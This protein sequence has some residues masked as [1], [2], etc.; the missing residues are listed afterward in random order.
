MNII[1]NDAIKKFAK[2]LDTFKY[3]YVMERI[4][5]EICTKYLI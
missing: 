4:Y 1:S 5:T 2:F 3:K